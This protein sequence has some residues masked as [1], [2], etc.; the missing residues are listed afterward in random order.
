MTEPEKADY[1]AAWVKRGEELKEITE[2]RNNFRELW[3]EANESLDVKDRAFMQLCDALN[4]FVDGASP[5]EWIASIKAKDAEIE[6]L[7]E[8]SV[9]EDETYERHDVCGYLILFYRYAS[10]AWP[11]LRRVE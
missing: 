4:E 2:S 7:R 9:W 8:Q 10:C 5:T 11:N 6:R 3:C 1:H